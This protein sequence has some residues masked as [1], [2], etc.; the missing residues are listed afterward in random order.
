MKYNTSNKPLQCMMTQSTCYKG[1]NKMA[2]KGVLWHSTGA[3]NPNLKRYVQ[4]DDNAPDR[5]SWLAKLGT[6]TYKNDWNHIDHQ[7]G[8][9]CWIGKLA[10]GTVTTVQTMPW[11]YRPW[12]CGSG[13]KGSCNTG[14][15]QFEICEDALTDSTYFNK[16]YTEACEITAY[17]CQMYGIDPN[18][19]VTVNG[20]QI[21]T[22]LCHADSHKLGFGSNHGDVNHWFPKFGKSMATARSDV[23]ALLK[24]AGVSTGITSTVTGTASTGSAADEKTIWDYLLSKIGNEYGVAG[25][26]GNLYAESGLRSNNL[27]N[28]YETKLGYTDATYT[29]AVDNGSYTNF[30]RDSAGYG[31]VQWTYYSR[32]QNLLNYATSK[33]KSIGDLATQLEF[34]YKEL[35]ESYVTTLNDLKS[36]TSVLS[37][38]NSVLT[39]FE[40]PAD[41]GTT[42]QTKR[43]SYGQTYYDKYAKK[44]PTTTQPVDKPVSTLDFSVGDIVNFTGTKHYVS[45]NAT[46]GSTVKASKAKITAIAMSGKHPYHCRAVNDAGSFVS[47]V[48]GWVDKDDVSNVSKPSTSNSVAST[49]TSSDIIYVV[50]SGDTLSGIASKY[51][52]T[53][54]VLATYNN[55]ANPN[56]I[57]VGQKIKIPSTNSLTSSSTT[58]W[59]PKVGDIVNYNGSVHYSSANATN[60]VNCKGG[61]AKIT[62]IYQLGK[63]KHPYHLIRVTG[64]GA[65]VYGWVDAGTFTKT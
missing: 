63:S 54:Q 62:S 59:T 17:L 11:D 3:N 51:G 25:L 45:A 40:R 37:A 50:K 38:S 15:I 55:I 43:A 13:S 53:Y 12:G 22:I 27:Q 10:D 19:T 65:T 20:V 34:L 39:K 32:K 36:A 42:V 5:A 1:T 9:N 60:A 29:A 46:S 41:Q 23:A 28:T 24:G 44:Q 14:W 33:K 64:S 2:V 16:V 61:Q 7:A 4:P 47:G 26:M 6:N 31:L 35:S 48:Y 8:L 18:G 57:T 52:T 58:T 21:P 30:V 49:G 56:V